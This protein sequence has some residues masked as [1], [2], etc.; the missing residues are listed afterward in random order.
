MRGCG[1]DGADPDPSA[2]RRRGCVPRADRP[3]PARAPG[4]PLPDRR[5]D[6]GR[7]GPAAGDAAGRL[8]RPRAVRGRAIVRAWLYRIATNRRSMRCGRAGAAPQTSGAPMPEPTRWN[9]PSGS[10]PTP[11]R[12]SRGSPTSAPGPEARYEAGRRSRWRSSS[13][14]STCRRS[15][16]RCSCCATC[17]ATRGGVAEMLKTSEAA[18]NSLLRRAREAFEARLPA[19]GRERAPLPSSKLERDVVGRF[20][21]TVEDGDI[22]G[23]VALLTDDAWL[24]MPPLPHAYQGREAIGAFLRGAEARRG[25]PLRL[26]PTRA[27]GQPAFGAL[28]GAGRG[29]VLAVRADA[30]GRPDLRDHLVRRQPRL[31]GSA[32][33]PRWAAS[34]AAAARRGRCRG[35]SARGPRPARSARRTA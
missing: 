8:A 6:P 3:V 2:R 25:A 14:F 21:E 32:F 5:L 28:P 1:H 9:E 24:T 17:S 26:L 23:M 31:P 12:C 15:S 16:A 18:V 29:R 11:T 33:R 22:D 10:S 34:A 20:A 27:N 4:A 30:R 35:P 13:A 19:A 7:R